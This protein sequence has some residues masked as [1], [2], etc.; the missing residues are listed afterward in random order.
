MGW[1]CSENQWQFSHVPKDLLQEADREARASIEGSA[2][3]PAA[4]A[5]PTGDMEVV[6]V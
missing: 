1:L 6:D 4:A 5:A 2:G 3:Q